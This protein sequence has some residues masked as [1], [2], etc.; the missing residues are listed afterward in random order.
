MIMC[1]LKIFKM[2]YILIVMLDYHKPFFIYVNHMWVQ[3]SLQITQL[4]SNDRCL[5][6]V[7]SYDGKWQAPDIGSKIQVFEI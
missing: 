6:L 3:E 7:N 2:Q 1:I 5:F 4:V